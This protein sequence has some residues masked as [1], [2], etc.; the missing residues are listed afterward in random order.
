MGSTS[1][2]NP[3]RT[4]AA[5]MRVWAF[6]ALVVAVAAVDTQV[7]CS[8]QDWLTDKIDN[9]ISLLKKEP[10][11]TSLH[12]ELTTLRT[13]LTD[14]FST[15][16][17]TFDDMDDKLA[18]LQADLK[19]IY[20]HEYMLG[21]WPTTNSGNKYQVIAAFNTTTNLGWNNCAF[22]KQTPGSYENNN[23]WFSSD[24]REVHF[25]I[26]ASYMQCHL[27]DFES[28]YNRYPKYDTRLTPDG[29]NNCANPRHN[30]PT[31]NCA[32]VKNV[33]NPGTN[34][35]QWL[36]NIQQTILRCYTTPKYTDYL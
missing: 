17:A 34:A 18:D 29:G 32:K 7:C 30:D 24:K 12:T 1:R 4:L 26:E 3:V 6:F 36:G 8:K 20:P 10:C 11:C 28:D 31:V 5:G 14:Y 9:L 25:T 19:W 21:H 22:D 2:W 23:C 35:F 27:F 16:T 33:G 13:M 15:Q